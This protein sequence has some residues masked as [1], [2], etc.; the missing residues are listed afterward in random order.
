MSVILEKG[1]NKYAYIGKARPLLWALL[2]Q[3]LLNEEDIEDIA[4]RFG[5]T[6][7]IEADFADLLV[8]LATNKCRFLI[9]DVV[10]D[11][12][13]AAKADDGNF[14]FLRTNAVFKKCMDLGAKRWKWSEKRLK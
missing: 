14:S 8:R 1:Q 4:A 3:A 2:C 12:A 9:A 10:A 7:S 5:R 6:L 11:K 13:Y